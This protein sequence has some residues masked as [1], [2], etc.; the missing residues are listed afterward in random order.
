[1]KALLTGATGFIGS[2]MAEHLLEK[3]YEVRCLVRTS[4]NLQWIADL[5]IQCYYGSLGDLDSLRRGLQDVDYV[6]H[7]AG[8]TKA[9]SRDEF[10]TAN[11][12]GTKNLLQ[13]LLENNTKL[14][15]FVFVSSQAAAGPSPTIEP[16][17][18]QVIPAPI[19]PYGTSK[20]EAEQL[21][22]SA[23]RRIPVTIVRPPAVYGPRDK[24]VLDFF[25]A[26]NFGI[27]P[28][29]GTR[30]KY[31]SL[32]HVRDLV[33][34]IFLAGTRKKAENQIYFLANPQPYSWEKIA[35]VTLKILNKRALRVTVPHLLLDG[36]S[37]VTEEIGK[38]TGK[39]SILNRQRVAE[40]KQDYWVCS[41]K[42]AKTDFKFETKIDLEEGI[43][44][45]IAWYKEKKWL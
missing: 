4:S 34:G 5:D 27:I 32:I 39:P 3:G 33:R 28:K 21:V 2:F 20:L 10:N 17:N 14:K 30:G 9:M 31:V 15:R 6:F 38:I 1:M 36:L 26:A 19:T 43:K 22:L 12:L 41:P 8:L 7:L 16:I 45:T 13:V 24:D 42:K 29:L 44:E 23:S 18:E 11:V 25:K 35:K 40:L 37:R